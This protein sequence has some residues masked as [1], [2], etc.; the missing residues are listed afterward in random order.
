MNASA[1]RSDD[2]IY[3][4]QR[5]ALRQSAVETNQELT[6]RIPTQRHDSFLSGVDSEKRLVH[7]SFSSTTPIKRKFG[8][9]VL[10]HDRSALDQTNLSRGLVPFLVDHDY[11]QTVG[12]VVDYALG[13]DKNFATA[14]IFKTPLGDKVL[15]QIE[16][17][18][19]SISAAYT[20]DEMQL[21]KET[22]DQE[23][24]S[25]SYWI[26][27]YTLLEVSSVPAGAD[28]TSR[29]GKAAMLAT[30]SR[31]QLTK[32]AILAGMRDAWEEE[33]EAERLRLLTEKTDALKYYHTQW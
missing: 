26:T 4:A 18:R 11:D 27:R 23:D 9:A 13:D 19:T 2:E 29:I 21:A 6:M 28:P 8:W 33:Q 3:R 5:T 32:E 22:P 12:E 7:F 31:E 17:G 24:N 25:Y 14:R 1:L 16:G 30:L 10:S 20:I 15:S